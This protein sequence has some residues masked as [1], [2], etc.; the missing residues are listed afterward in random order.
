M[1]LSSCRRLLSAIPLRV[2]TS[3]NRLVT[4]CNS[5]TPPR[6]LALSTPRSYMSTTPLE[7]SEVTITSLNESGDI[8]ETVS[9]NIDQ[10]DADRFAVVHVKGVQFK[11]SVND[12]IQVDT[13][14][15]EPGTKITLDK[16]LLVGSL[17][18]TLIG[19]PLLP[20]STV[21]VTAMV[22]ERGRGPY[23]RVYNSG[24]HHTR[25][26]FWG[27]TWHHMHF[28]ESETTMLRIRSIEVSNCDLQD[29]GDS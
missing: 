29:A 14:D 7:T 28:H 1:S 10:P 3:S 9:T 22:I 27:K 6:C 18:Y 5:I 20:A 11:V 16:V 19:R 25:Q 2:V 4:S 8:L 24:K 26:F 21:T 15:L 23:L 13:L 12:V 17:N